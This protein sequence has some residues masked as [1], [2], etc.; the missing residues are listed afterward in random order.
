MIPFINRSLNISGCDEDED[1]IFEPEE[2]TGEPCTEEQFKAGRVTG[3][4]N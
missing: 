3:S 2:W 1:E 4:L